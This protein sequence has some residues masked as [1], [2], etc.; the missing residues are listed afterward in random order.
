M[1]C[2]VR[3]TSRVVLLLRSECLIGVISLNYSYWTWYY[4]NHYCKQRFS[5]VVQVI[6][7]EGNIRICMW[8]FL[9]K[10]HFSCKTPNQN[11]N[12]FTFI[13][14]VIVT[15]PCLWISQGLSP[16]CGFQFRTM[17][18]CL[19]VHIYFVFWCCSLREYVDLSVIY[20]IEVNY[21]RH[22]FKPSRDSR[23]LYFILILN[24]VTR[25]C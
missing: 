4:Y 23:V 12:H 25:I 17:S 13:V 6:L 24:W 18:P 10:A 14:S 19:L 11:R 16:N 21:Q 22:V 3:S 1:S 15:C 20:L 7:L 8:T 2:F 9:T 5:L